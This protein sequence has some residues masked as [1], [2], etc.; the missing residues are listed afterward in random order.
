MSHQPSDATLVY[1][2]FVEVIIQLLQRNQNGCMSEQVLFTDYLP[3]LGLNKDHHLPHQ[4]QKVG[5]D[6]TPCCVATTRERRPTCTSASCSLCCSRAWMCGHQVEDLIGKRMVAEVGRPRRTLYV[7]SW[8]CAP[9]N[10][11]SADLY[12]PAVTCLHAHTQAY[13]KKRKCNATGDYEYLP[14]ARAQL[15]RL[16][17]EAY[18]VSF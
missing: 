10:P 15:T 6:C 12:A 16:T 8:S 5:P 7:A 3:K 4:T 14:G 1:I 13:L 17:E 18:K 11:D 9:S 2:G